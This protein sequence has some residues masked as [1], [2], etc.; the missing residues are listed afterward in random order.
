MH[1]LHERLLEYSTKPEIQEEL[2]EAKRLHT[3]FLEKFPLEEIPNMTLE[4]YALGRT[5]KGSFGWWLEYNT[6]PLGSIKGGSAAKHIIYFRKK[7]NQWQF[8]SKFP[9]V[10]VAWEQLKQ[11]MQQLLQSFDGDIYE[12][13]EEDNLLYS[14]N[15][16]KGK[17]LYMYHPDKLLTIY[18][19][20]HLKKFLNELGVD[21]SSLKGKDSVELNILLREVISTNDAIKEFDPILVAMFLYYEF[22]GEEQYLKVAPGRDATYWDE[23]LEG[24]YISVGWNEV[25]DLTEFN[26]YD[27]FKTA[28]QTHNFQNSPQKNTEKAN[29]LWEFYQLKPGEKVIANKGKSQI[30]AIGTVT[31]KGYEYRDDLDNFKHVVYVKWNT[32]FDPVL[33]IPKQENWGFKTVAKVGKKQV[34][35]WTTN[36]PT[37]G[38]PTK[39][40]TSEEELF[41]EMLEQALNRKGQI[42]LY[43]PPGT[44]KTYMARKFINW[45]NEKDELFKGMN[46]NPLKTWL[47]VASERA[48]DFRWE[49][50]MDGSIERWNVRTVVKNFKNAK[51][52]EKILCYRG[53]SANNALVGIAEV[54]EEFKDDSIGVKGIRSF[55]SEI[56]YDDYK[57]T[58]EYQS[59]QAGK[60]GNRGTMFEVNEEFVNWVK[61]ALVELEDLESASILGN[62]VNQNNMEIC[63]F[64]P[65]YQYEDFMEGFKPVQSDNG[66]IAFKLEKGIFHRFAE[67]AQENEES[68][69][70]FIIDELNRGNVPKIFGEMITLLE[71]DKRGVEVRLPQSKDTFSIPK[72]LFMIGTMNTSDRSIKMMDAALKRRFAF[73]ECMPKYELINHPIDLLSITPADVLRSI[74]EKLVH[75]QGRDKQIGHA[76][77][78]KD[79]EQVTSIDELKEIFKLEII[80]L[81]Q[82]YCFDDYAQLAEIIGEDFV[83]VDG[84]D[85]NTE[86]LYGTDDAFI[87]AIEKQFK[88]TVA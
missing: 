75:L 17:I 82:E 65:S 68:N 42:I 25:G 1:H 16:L 50:I 60:M 66:T 8:P 56:S 61:D 9:N 11:D 78:M 34:L 45:K 74:N 83:D 27:E 31:D 30:L 40:Y 22:M 28:F 26:D 52:G 76:Y 57:N 47:M 70:Y 77:F 43:G 87:Q 79:G 48:D 88:G 32:V 18:N 41:F 81:V 36:K 49:Q 6:I 19:G 62:Y 55:E 53:G 29:E 5:K 2:Q 7:D 10:E 44:G 59:T 46:E 20:N 13:I 37:A 80:P 51:K 63:T 38:P 4:Q 64:H 86:L 67:K 84:M 69:F 54:V 21:E 33:E 24:S 73:I 71:M 58:T 72:N 23:C 35:E 15:M 12:G 85:I 39:R 3:E 14:A